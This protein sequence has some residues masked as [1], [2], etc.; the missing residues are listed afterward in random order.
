MA[1]SLRMPQSR[2]AEQRT[3]LVSNFKNMAAH[4]YMFLSMAWSHLHLYRHRREQCTCARTCTNG[5]LAS[6]SLLSAL[7]HMSSRKKFTQVMLGIHPLPASAAHLSASWTTAASNS[8][9]WLAPPSSSLNPTD[10]MMRRMRSM[11]SGA[12]PWLSK[13]PCKD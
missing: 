12:A 13:N 8:K 6:V 1:S 11:R 4:L 3:L 2:H 5:A 7:A 10:A 9:D